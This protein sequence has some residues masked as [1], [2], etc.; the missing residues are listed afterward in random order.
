MARG[1]ENFVYELLTDVFNAGDT[2]PLA[3]EAIIKAGSYDLGPKSTR[4]EN[5]EEWTAEK[6][7]E[8]AKNLNAEKGPA[9]DFDD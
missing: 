1:V 5:P 9:G 4:I 7:H 2:A 3:I 6:I 8:R